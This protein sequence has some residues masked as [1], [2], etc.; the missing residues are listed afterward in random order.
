MPAPKGNQYAKGCKNS[1]RPRKVLD[2]KILQDL[3]EIQCTKVEICKI[4][5]CDKSVL[6][7]EEYASIIEKGYEEGK[8]SLRRAL[9]YTA[10]KK[11]NATILIWLSKQHLGMREPD[12]E[13]KEDSKGAF[14]AYLAKQKQLKV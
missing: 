10:T 1:G 2:K 11:L 12:A 14:N 13:I 7:H 8:K 5:D 6:Q 3:A 9:F 4:L